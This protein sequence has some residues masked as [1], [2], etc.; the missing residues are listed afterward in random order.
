[1]FCVTS[2]ATASSFF[3]CSVNRLMPALESGKVSKCEV[4]S[5]NKKQTTKFV[6]CKSTPIYLP[7]LFLLLSEA[8][9]K[10]KR[11]Y[12]GVCPHSYSG[13]NCPIPRKRVRVQKLVT[14]LAGLL[15]AQ[16]HC[17]PSPRFF[18]GDLRKVSQTIIRRFFF[19]YHDL[20]GWFDSSN[21][22]SKWGCTSIPWN[23]YRQ[24]SSGHT[25]CT[26]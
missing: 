21:V 23:S 26:C 9:D 16:S 12:L 18:A 7:S 19:L 15:S 14:L 13:F 2:T 24:W 22:R 10:N 3:S 25:T 17:R 6:L 1:M 8:L 20:L 5:F 4:S 11:N